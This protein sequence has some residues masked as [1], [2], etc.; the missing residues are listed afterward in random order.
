MKLQHVFR[1]SFPGFSTIYEN[2]VNKYPV[3]KTTFYEFH[4]K[5]LLS[6][7][8]HRWKKRHMCVE[9]IFVYR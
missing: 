3:M 5:V 4:H 6:K 9:K 1:K 8:L 2:L 7:L